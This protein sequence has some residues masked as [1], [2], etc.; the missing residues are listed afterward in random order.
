MAKLIWLMGPSGSGK[1]SVLFAL[2]TLSPD[3][4]VV[5]HRYITRP[6]WQGT[7]NYISLS[8]HEFFI[9][10][11]HQFFSLSWFAHHH[12]YGIGKEIDLWLAAGVNVIVNGSRAHLRQAELRY[13]RSLIPVALTVSPDKLRQRLVRRGRENTEDI[14]ARLH[15][16]T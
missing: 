11:A 12:Y 7:E 2:R 15:R 3:N 9:R 5:A 13:N 6:A 14:S 10:E 1:D 16:A 4:L 8:E